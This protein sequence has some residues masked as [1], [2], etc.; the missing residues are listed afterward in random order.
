MTFHV[1]WS[2]SALDELATIWMRANSAIRQAITVASHS[3][4]QQLQNDPE[5]QGESR[6]EEERFFFASPLGVSFEIDV[7]QHRVTIRHV[8]SFR[9]RGQ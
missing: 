5:Q 4:D 9:K 7:R 2:Q 8:W 1:N 6:G 3:I